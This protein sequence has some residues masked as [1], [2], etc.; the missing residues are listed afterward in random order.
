M[1][2]ETRVPCPCGSDLPIADFAL[3]SDIFPLGFFAQHLT[4]TGINLQLPRGLL[5]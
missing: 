1:Y 2:S 3:D 5:G 4:E